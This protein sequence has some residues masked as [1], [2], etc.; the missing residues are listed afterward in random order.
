MARLTFEIEGVKVLSRNLRVLADDVVSMKPEFE[1]IGKIIVEG[2][3][4]N[5]ENQGTEEGKWQ[6]LSSSTLEARRKRSGHYKNPP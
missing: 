3:Q 4:K 1:E 6:S 5:F 2:A